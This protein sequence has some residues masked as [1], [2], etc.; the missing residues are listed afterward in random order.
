MPIRKWTRGKLEERK[1]PLP[2]EEETTESK[3]GDTDGKKSKKK[4]G[5]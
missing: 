5:S 4:S 1:A 2:V 3:K